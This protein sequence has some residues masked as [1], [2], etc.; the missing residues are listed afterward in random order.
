MFP[1]IVGRTT[2]KLASHFAVLGTKLI[3]LERLL[4]STTIANTL[5]TQYK[6]GAVN[7]VSPLLI[8]LWSFSPLGGQAILRILSTEP[9]LTNGTAPVVYFNTS[10]SVG[11]VS[12]LNN[13]DPPSFYFSDVPSIFTSAIIAPLEIQQSSMDQ[14][15]N[16][17]IPMIEGLDAT[18][19][20]KDGW[21]P[22]PANN[23]VYSSLMGNPVAGLPT[24]G[25]SRFRHI[26][27]YFHLNCTEPV[28]LDPSAEVFWSIPDTAGLC[29]P[30]QKF[31]SFGSTRVKNGTFQGTFS[32]GSLQDNT[33]DASFA[34]QNWPM[35]SR[36]ILFQSVSYY[37]VT[38]SNCTVRYPTVESDITCS[39][40]NCSV[41]RIRPSNSTSPELSPLEDCITAKNFY[42]EFAKL[43]S[44]YRTILFNYS[45]PSETE[46]YLMVGKSPLSLGLSV[47][48]GSN[49]NSVATLS[50][51]S[52]L[53]AGLMSERLAR[54]MNTYF[55]ASM[56][57]EYIA[58][59]VSTF[60]YSDPM[61]LKFH[62]AVF[63]DA[64]WGTTENVY[65]CNNYWLFV[66]LISSALLLFVGVMGMWFKFRS[67]AP[68]IF[69]RVSSLTRDNPYVRIPPGGSTLDGFIRAKL[70]QDVV[71]K[72]GDV[73]PEEAVGHVA[74]ASVNEG[75][76]G[77]IGTLRRDRL[78][79]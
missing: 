76:R 56:V 61:M 38:V 73:R 10:F 51:M 29:R 22:V 49:I 31:L 50:N 32:V 45:L 23:V 6:L 9:R 8:L 57:P 15:G 66:L 2:E 64:T 24:L 47:Q 46:K 65:V 5:W 16:V 12:Y 1:A 7:L 70:L 34:N 20:D 25:Q 63:T 42:K 21:I 33:W 36:Q 79:Y 17:K 52:N 48:T 74:L 14:F 3:T 4:G 78:Y 69:G 18:T 44:P 75:L 67:I 43:G 62:P 58:G 27:S 60:N 40:K 72:L 54:V 26:S 13:M 39:R 59:A 77:E 68:D 71:V 19:A 28:L 30:N 37:G 53:T 11:N 35:K 55:M 41:T